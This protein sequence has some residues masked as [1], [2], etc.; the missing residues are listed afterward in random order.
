[1]SVFEHMPMGEEGLREIYSWIDD[2]V[3]KNKTIAEKKSA[4]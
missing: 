4:R 3:K 1:M 2:F